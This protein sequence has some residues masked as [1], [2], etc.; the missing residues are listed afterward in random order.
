MATATVKENGKSIAATGL[1]SLDMN[2]HSH[3]TI[4]SGIPYRMRFV[5]EGVAP[6]LFHRYDCEAV[7]A[8]AKAGKGSAEKKSDNVDSYYYRDEEGRVCVPGEHVHGALIQAGRYE[9][10]PRSSRKSAMD[11]IKAGVI[12]EDNLIPVTRDDEFIMTA[13]YLDKRRVTVMRA[14]IAR[15][16]PA[17]MK[18]WRCEFTLLIATPELISPQLLRN[19]MNRAGMLCGW[20]DF[21]PQHGRFQVVSAE[22]QTLE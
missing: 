9:Q 6:I 11:L 19:L 8:K 10:D 4:P 5:V 16:R 21:R 15:V 14:A 13:D 2:V 22:I 3:D 12:C 1:H 18:G 7:D 20:G 17:L